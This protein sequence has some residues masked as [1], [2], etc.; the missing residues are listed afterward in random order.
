MRWK[1]FF[2]RNLNVGKRL[3]RLHHA[4]AILFLLLTITGFI[5]FSSDFRSAFPGFRVDVK[6]VHIWIGIISMLPLF[7]YL[8]KMTKHLNRLRKRIN[9]RNNLFFVIFILVILIVSGLFLTFHRIFPPVISTFMLFVHDIATWVGVPYLVYHS[10]T[11]SKW[12]KKLEK[13]KNQDFK[14]PIPVEHG[15]P[16]LKRRTFLRKLAGGLIVV[17]SIPFIGNWLKT[18]FPS[19]GNF[20]N[21]VKANKFRP[22]PQPAPKSKPPIGGGRNG[23]FR[24]YT[25]TEMPELTNENWS[26]TIDGLVDRPN[27][28]KWNEFLK[29]GRDVQV[30]DFHCVTGWSV[31]D[32]TWE[33]IPLRRFLENAGVDK[34]AKYVKFYSADG[35]YTDTLSIDQATQDG[36]MVAMLIDGELITNRNGGPVRLI[37]PKMYAYKSVKWLNRIELIENEHIGFWEQRGYSQNAWVKK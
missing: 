1:L 24:Y 22:L 10:I 21:E 15:N 7:F 11:R 28:Y 17:V 16:L 34:K 12:F 13:N 14:Q 35:V 18:Y 5:L 29:L 26:F 4:N 20:S 6:N 33:G 3:V 32:V 19:L 36:V 2:T 30:S 23:E 27:T 8:P 9:H 37:V 25:V 31:Y